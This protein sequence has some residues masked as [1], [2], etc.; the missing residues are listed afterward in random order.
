MTLFPLKLHLNN[1]KHSQ[2]C[3]QSSCSCLLMLLMPKPSGFVWCFLHNWAIFLH[4]SPSFMQYSLFWKIVGLWWHSFQMKTQILLHVFSLYISF[5]CISNEHKPVS[6]CLKYLAGSFRWK[7]A[8]AEGSG[9]TQ[10]RH[11]FPGW[12]ADPRRGSGSCCAHL[13]QWEDSDFQAL[14]LWRHTSCK[15][16]FLLCNW[17]L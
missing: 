14:W 16:S 13:H 1:K 6:Q 17:T 12:P 4:H 10:P 7:L 3:F 9:E 2:K 15:C 8:P 5:Q 11:L